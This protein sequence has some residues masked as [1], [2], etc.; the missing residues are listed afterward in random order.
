MPSVEYAYQVLMLH[1]CVYPY[2]NQLKGMYLMCSPCSYRILVA[3]GGS[4]RIPT[5]HALHWVVHSML[6]QAWTNIY[7][8]VREHAYSIIVVISIQTI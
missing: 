2:G 8:W 1:D 4:E 6:K 3:M 5:A 7:V